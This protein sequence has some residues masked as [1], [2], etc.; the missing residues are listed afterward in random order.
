MCK[1]QRFRLKIKNL[2]LKVRY[3]RQD[4]CNG[5]YLFNTTVLPLAI[6]RPPAL[7]TSTQ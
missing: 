2:R 4:A 3:L 6:C 5:D 7:I 1:A